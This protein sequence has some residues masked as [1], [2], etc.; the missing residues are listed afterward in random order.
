LLFCLLAVVVAAGFV[1]YRVWDLYRTAKGGYAHL[2]YLLESG[3]TVEGAP[4]EDVLSDNYLRSLFGDNPDLVEQ[5]KS[6]VDLGMATDANLKLG[7]VAAMVV[8]YRKNG[9]DILDPAIYAIGGFP[10]P[11]SQRL[12]FHATGY[13]AQEFDPSLWNFG[14]TLVRLLGRDVIVFCEQDKAEHHMEL[15]FDLLNGDVFRLAQRIVEAPL[16]Y[17]FVFPEPGEVAPPN[18]KNAVQT[19]LV[20]GSM[21]GDKGSSEWLF[22]CPDIRSAGHVETLCRDTLAVARATFH[23]KYGGYIKHMPWGDMNDNWWATEYVALLDGASIRQ[24]QKVVRVRADQTRRQNN[25]LLKTLERVGRDLAAQK[26]F[27]AGELPWEFAHAVKDSSSGGHWSKE[28][29]VGPDWPFGT[30]GI[31]TT[32]S[33]AEEEERARLKAEREAEAAAEKARREAEQAAPAAPES[34]EA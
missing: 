7:N 24:E 16:Y 10:D 27:M 23:D 14:N 9:D 4:A 1:S 30:L 29:I 15:L 22:M 33:I 17:T 5:L 28:H 12:G 25:A 31:P 20:R 19:V 8:T 11:K 18:V 32:G 21:E 3:E 13:L 6:V 2:R 34:P 26:A